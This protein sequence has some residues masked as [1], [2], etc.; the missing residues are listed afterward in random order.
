M[1]YVD[2]AMAAKQIL[3]SLTEDGHVSHE[4]LLDAAYELENNIYCNDGVPM[5]MPPKFDAIKRKHI[6]AKLIRYLENRRIKPHY[7]QN[8]AFEPLPNVPTSV[9]PDN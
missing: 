2:E 1:T 7:T 3:L 9:E 6:V 4:L 5:R 8:L